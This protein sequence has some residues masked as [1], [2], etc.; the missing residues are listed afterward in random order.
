MI[1][2]ALFLG[3]AGALALAAAGGASAQS[4]TYAPPPSEN[5]LR[6]QER[7]GELE[8]AL[9]QATGENERLAIELRR[10]RSENAR[11]ERLLSDA[12]G[13][14]TGETPGP[15]AGLA[16]PPAPGAAGQLGT[17]PAANPAV[18]SAQQLRDATRFL[19][20]GRYAEAEAA[21][22]A[23]AQANPQAP[24]TPEARYFVGRTQ[25]AQRRFSD[26]AD[27]FI[28]FVTD[29]PNGARAPDAWAMLGVSLKGMDKIDQACG[30][31]RDLPVKYPRASTAVRNLAASEARAANCATR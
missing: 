8:G 15:V 27:T 12:T 5:L 29:Y 3:A 24:D 6:L 1:R 14:G 16:P 31:F 2:L 30:V 23:Y 21:F 25:W 9:R 26:A 17:L 22:A 28:K 4:V 18:D 7:V 11:L 20:L 19:Q 13:A 10:A